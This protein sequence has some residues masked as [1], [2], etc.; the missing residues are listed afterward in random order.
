MKTF[1]YPESLIKEYE[2]WVVL[3]RPKQPTIGALVV[4]H[5]SDATALSQIC[6]DSF[7]ELK[8]I[9]DEIETALGDLFDFQKINYMM[10]MMV[11]PH[12]HYHVIPRYEQPKDFQGIKCVD[13]GWP[14][15]PQ[16][17]DALPLD[18]GQMANLQKLIK[19]RWQ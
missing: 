8:I 14:A 11:D 6:A 9:T 17:G 19:S 15:L 7:T 18:G 3:L 5:K 4:V 1:L 12:V 16:L 10:L 2:H 13:K